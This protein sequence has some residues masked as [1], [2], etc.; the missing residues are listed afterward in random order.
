MISD[1]LVNWFKNLP[2]EAKIELANAMGMD[3]Q[4]LRNYIS[5]KRTPSFER[6]MIML[7]YSATLA[8][9][10]GTEKLAP[11]DLDTSCKINVHIEITGR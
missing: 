1:N 6:A 3:V 9:K 2:P 8:S 10:F 11:S 7:N 5:L 4:T